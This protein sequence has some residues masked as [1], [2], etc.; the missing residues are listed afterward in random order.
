[1]IVRSWSGKACPRY[2]YDYSVLVVG[3][4]TIFLSEPRNAKEKMIRTDVETTSD[5][6]KYARTCCNIVSCK[7]YLFSVL[8]E[9]KPRVVS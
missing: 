5:I 8:V 7:K 1:M 4:M 6:R 9:I 2:E 3:I